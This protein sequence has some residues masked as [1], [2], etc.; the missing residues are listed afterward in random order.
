MIIRS[1]VLIVDARFCSRLFNLSIRVTLNVVQPLTTNAGFLAIVSWNGK[2]LNA[3]NI[4]HRWTYAYNYSLSHPLF[5][6][7]DV[8]AKILA[9]SEAGR[10]LWHEC[11]SRYRWAARKLVLNHC[12]LLRPFIPESTI[13]GKM[14][15]LW[16]RRNCNY[17]EFFK[18]LHLT[19]TW[20]KFEG[21]ADEQYFVDF[22]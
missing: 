11:E 19:D 10:R 7:L 14:A 20:H 9:R 21:Y 6:A 16:Y 18:F 12:E 3:I 15:R 2:L 5:A 8:N 22:L 4:I 17:L 1:C 13:K